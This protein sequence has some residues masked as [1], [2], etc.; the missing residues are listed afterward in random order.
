[1]YTGATVEP[2]GSFVS[3]LFTKWGD[4]DIS[5][6]ILTG[7]HISNTGKRQKESLLA[8]LV[9]ALRSKG[10]HFRDLELYAY[11]ELVAAPCDISQYVVKQ[12]IYKFTNTSFPIHNM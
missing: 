7:S 3:E 2:I 11:F 4:L 12:S 1:M 10:N 8:D 6:E 5:V 9:G